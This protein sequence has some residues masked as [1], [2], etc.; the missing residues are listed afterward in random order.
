MDAS[1]EDLDALAELERHLMSQLPVELQRIALNL[2]RQ[3]N[4]L[5]RTMFLFENDTLPRNKTFQNPVS[6][7]AIEDYNQFCRFDFLDMYKWWHCRLAVCI[8]IIGAVANVLTVTTLTR[9]NM[10]N[11][12]NLLLL[13][14]AVAD[15][16]VVTEYVPY[17]TSRLLGGQALSQS[18]GHAL[19]ILIHAHLSQV[20]HTIA[21]WL[22]IS[23]AIWRWVAVCRP[24]VAPTACTMIR[25]WR[26]LCSVYIA[27]PLLA[28]PTFLMYTVQEYPDPTAPPD[29]PKTF[30]KVDFSP[31]ALA[32]DELLKKVNFLVYSVIVKLIPCLMLKLLMPA[33]IRGMWIAKRR[34]QR[35]TSRKPP[36]NV[37]TTTLITDRQENVEGASP[38]STAAAKGQNPGRKCRGILQQLHLGRTKASSHITCSSK[39][40][41]NV[42]KEGEK[43]SQ[44]KKNE[45]AT[46]RTTT[47]LL[48]VMFL[49]LLTE[50][51]QG[52]L[53][54]LS[55]IYGQDFFS[56]CYLQ[57]GDPMDLLALI[58]SSIN[59]LLYCVMSKQFRDTFFGLY[60]C[61][62]SK[63]TYR[64]C[65]KPAGHC[66]A[67][68][69]YI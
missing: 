13:G 32:N 58:N 9:K 37:M 16:L 31:L 68:T 29:D 28:T 21:I 19:Y 24:H 18:K 60:C 30:Y 46:E 55:L 33:I 57:L 40:E 45:G 8:G 25:A 6:T 64:N 63:Q 1:T 35:L 11:P 17:A 62:K 41:M 7:T 36:G 10:S 22:T 51:P 59:F 20:C 3:D 5:F 12:T 39:T 52:L 65:G 27:C 61:R 69:S 44:Q 15:M 66:A 47:M 42:V 50:A 34:R 4:A 14:L 53:T 49:F 38:P 56:A 54:G 43:K 48:V 23:L 26:V 67:I 2:T